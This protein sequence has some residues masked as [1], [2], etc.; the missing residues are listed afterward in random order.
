MTASFVG[1]DVAVFTEAPASIPEGVCYRFIPHPPSAPDGH[2][3]QECE[4]LEQLDDVMF[5]AIT[6]NAEALLKART[7]W[8]EV[9]DEYGWDLVEES[10][11]QYLRCAIDAMT[12]EDSEDAESI[13]RATMVAEVIE[14]LTAR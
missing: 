3:D 8:P 5:S 11:S 4:L 9:I 7:M 1:S 14:L 12:Q 13:D 6:G 2:S 10:R